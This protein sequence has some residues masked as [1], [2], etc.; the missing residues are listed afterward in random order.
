MYVF[1]SRISIVKFAPEGTGHRI[2]T[3]FSNLYRL[4]V[5]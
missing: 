2:K 3:E 4:T 1:E 5:K